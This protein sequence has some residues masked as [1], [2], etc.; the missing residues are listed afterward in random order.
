MK[1]IKRVLK[2]ILRV[3]CLSLFEEINGVEEILK[4]DPAEIYFRMDSKM[5]LIHIY[6]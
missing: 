5:F 2:E 6:K 3:N 1:K 4:K